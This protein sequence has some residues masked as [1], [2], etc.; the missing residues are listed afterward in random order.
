MNDSKKKTIGCIAAF[1]LLVTAVAFAS[2]LLGGSPSS[3]GP[4]FILWG[5]APLLV[6]IL[7]RIVTRDWSDAGFKPAIRKNVRW[8]IISIL[9][10][11]VIM[12]LTLLFG[13]MVSASSVIGF[14]MASYIKMVLPGMAV[15]FIFAIF[16]E[17]GWRGYL[18]PKLSSLGI[19]DYLACAIVAVVWATWHLPFIRE[20]TWTYAGPESLLTFIPRF[21]LGCFAMAIFY[22]EL[23]IMTG[24]VWP[25]VL[26]HC[27]T[28]SIQHP[29]AADFL[30]IVPGT[31]YLVS[32][33]GLF[34][35]AATGLLGV[36]LNLWR[37]RKVSLAGHLK[38]LA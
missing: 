13:A 30:K 24:S 6:A 8:Y 1:I 37:K 14:S 29:L 19:N 2:P 15:F 32:F 31:E 7:L 21:Y 16:E 17:F 36:A 12:A 35:I 5:I 11:P 38:S 3:F 26:L 28:N 4:G 22:N 20:L 25:A 18:S 34:M 23:R 33:N 27:L 10:C 9:A